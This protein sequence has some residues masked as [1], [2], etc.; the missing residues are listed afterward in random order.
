[1]AHATSMFNRSDRFELAPARV[2]SV[3]KTFG[4]LA[5]IAAIQ[6]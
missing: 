5:V 4:S 6:Q 3:P 2:D 1:M